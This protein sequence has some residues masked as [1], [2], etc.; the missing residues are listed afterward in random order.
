MLDK[1]NCVNV[2][3]II[4]G[5]GEMTDSLKSLTKELNLENKVIFTG[6]LS[7]SDALSI[8]NSSDAFWS[9]YDITNLGNPLL[10]SAYLGKPIITLNDRDLDFLFEDRKLFSLDEFDKL[11]DEAYRGLF[12]KDKNLEL[13]HDS[14]ILK[15]K[16]ISWEKRINNEMEWINEKL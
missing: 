1:Y 11:V 2:K 8:L 9:F 13:K 14:V 15:S 10:E 6:A 7:H 16:L 12:E 5:D 4:I 3:L